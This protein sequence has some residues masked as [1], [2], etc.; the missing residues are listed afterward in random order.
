VYLPQFIFRLI[1]DKTVERKA[2]R[3]KKFL[4]APYVKQR[5]FALY[6]VVKAE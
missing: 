5:L 4:V 6:T 1:D 3:I 2:G